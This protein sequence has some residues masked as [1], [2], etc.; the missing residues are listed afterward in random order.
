LLAKPLVGMVRN[1]NDNP[2]EVIHVAVCLSCVGNAGGLQ[3][4]A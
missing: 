4:G 3:D 1:V 2:K